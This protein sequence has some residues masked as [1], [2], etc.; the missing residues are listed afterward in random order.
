MKLL[1][2]FSLLLVNC[3]RDGYNIRSA[4][5]LGNAKQKFMIGAVIARDFKTPKSLAFDFRDLFTFELINNGISIQN[6]STPSE[7]KEVDLRNKQSAF[8]LS[9]R[10]SAGE[11]RDA[12]PHTER[13]LEKAE[14]QSLYS[15][16]PFDYFVQGV[17]S[18][19]TNDA[20]LEQKSDHLIFLNIYDR[21]GN[22]ALM[23]Q[24]TFAGKPLRES[25][26]MRN[27]ASA[28]AEAARRAWEAKK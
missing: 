14:I 2:F 13:L 18:L 26:Q 1:I 8:P 20:V 4:I 21:E 17:I 19:H 3:G 25:E 22:I 9:L 24:S 27:L 5:H 10:S 28:F 11:T 15:L 16:I 6:L 12:L 23:I 7:T